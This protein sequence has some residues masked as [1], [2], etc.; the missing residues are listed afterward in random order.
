MSSLAAA[1]D[2]ARRPRRPA[3]GTRR[4][5]RAPRGP[6][7]HRQ[8]AAG[9]G[10]QRAQQVDLGEHLQVVAGLGRAGLH[11]VLVV[12]V[13]AGDLEHVEHVV[14]VQLGQAVRR[15]RARQV[16]VAVEVE[17]LAGQQ[18]VHVGVAAR[19]QQVVHAAAVA[20]DAVAGQRV[21]GDGGH[22]AQ[23]GQRRPEAVMGA[24]VGLLQLA[25][26]RGPHA[27]ARVVQVP[28]VE[29]RHL[30][31]FQR[32]DAEHVAGRHLPG[33]A[34]ADRHHVRFDQL[35]LRRIGDQGNGRT[36]CPRS[37]W[38]LCSPDMRRV[39]RHGLPP[40]HPAG[41]AR[42]VEQFSRQYTGAARS[43]KGSVRGGKTFS[44]R[45][46]RRPA[47]A[48]A[49]RMGKTDVSLATAPARPARS[50]QHAPAD[51]AADRAY[52]R[53]VRREAQQAGAVGA[54]R[55]FRWTE[56]VGRPA[57]ERWRS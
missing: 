9:A 24:D 57:A 51:P 19:A 2:P 28:H 22:G 3:A 10:G 1:P 45:A 5:D 47:L 11:E 29:V 56:A 8:V 20:V 23:V 32:D 33:E 17:V 25:R 34:A 54:V 39:I 48:G 21:L 50:R 16:R 49:G 55:G 43:W 13:Q 30:R 53:P 18:L 15:H 4:W 6:H 35:A 36:P 46:W 14:H 7:R 42:I 12:V 41:L 44:R 27:F 40:V 38:S 31:A 37:G 26:A 52:Q